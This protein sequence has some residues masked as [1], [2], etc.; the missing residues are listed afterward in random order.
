MY[1]DVST[2]G[3]F[4]GGL[5]PIIIA[6]ITT[7]GRKIKAISNNLSF[8]VFTVRKSILRKPLYVVYSL[9]RKSLCGNRGRNCN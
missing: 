7:Q 9:R 1:P 4:V 2:L 3:Y 6:F 5:N 8:N